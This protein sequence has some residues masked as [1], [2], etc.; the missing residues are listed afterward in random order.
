MEFDSIVIVECRVVGE[1]G[2]PV[3]VA[4]SLKLG[5][6]RLASRWRVGVVRELREELS[7]LGH[8]SL[9]NGLT[10]H[11]VQFRSGT[12]V[13][14]AGTAVVEITLDSLS[15]RLGGG[16]GVAGHPVAP[17]TFI[18]RGCPSNP[19]PRDNML[20]LPLIAHR[21]RILHPRYGRHNT[22]FSRQALENTIH[23]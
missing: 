17:L 14:T 12:L 7:G 15:A 2:V 5:D 4:D 10:D 22:Q 20:H 1:G 16:F 18:Y 23:P 11:G 21:P 8:P 3:A 6:E 13:L 19:V 9:S